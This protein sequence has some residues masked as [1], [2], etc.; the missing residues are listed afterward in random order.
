[1]VIRSQHGCFGYN[2]GHRGKKHVLLF[3]IWQPCWVK[4]CYNPWRFPNLKENIQ[5]ERGYDKLIHH[6]PLTGDIYE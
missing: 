3:L 1:M 4:I 5:L 6:R 2:R